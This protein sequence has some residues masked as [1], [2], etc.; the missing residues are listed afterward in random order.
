MSLPRPAPIVDGI[1]RKEHEMLSKAK[2]LTL[3]LAAL[4]GAAVGGAAI[5]GA[6]TS[7]SSTS[8][9]PARAAG[10]PR[11]APPGMRNMPAPGGTAH[12]AAE[13]RSPATT[14]QRRRR[15]PSKPPVAEPP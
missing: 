8:N 2:K 7:N 1:Q 14:Q 12:E 9:A 10:M 5:A 4:A 6:A 15:P 13:R 3:T 11:P